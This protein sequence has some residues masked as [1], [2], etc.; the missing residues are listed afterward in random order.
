MSTE[1][2]L[3]IVWSTD[4]IDLSDPFQ[5]QWLLRQTLMYG[6]AEDIRAL[7][8][9]EVERELDKLDLPHEIASLWRLFLEQHHDS[10]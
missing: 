5:R 4:H 3:Y 8:F 10:K 9:E 1:I 2:P 7:D 6:R